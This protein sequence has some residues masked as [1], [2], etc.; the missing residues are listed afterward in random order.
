MSTM[1]A[2]VVGVTPLEAAAVFGAAV[3]APAAGEGLPVRDTPL[4]GDVVCW[5]VQCHGGAGASTIAQ[6]LSHIGDG[7][8]AWPGR[9]DESPCVVLV[10]RES[11]EG[12]NAAHRAIRQYL[13]GAVPE[14]ITVVGL[15]L[16][17][18]S[19]ARKPSPQVRQRSK[20]V[21]SALPA[22]VPVWRVQWHDYLLSSDRVSLPVATAATEPARK[23]S[24][25][26]DV[27]AD[28]LEVGREAALQ[29]DALFNGQ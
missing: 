27:P 9:D 3:V 8:R 16:V 7:G 10:A 26:T 25:D 17:A 15:A 5:L 21:T 14:H 1:S 22:S 12:L 6:M 4:D 28:V 13:A 2:E 23:F 19:P 18:A 29:V 11:L 20:L 24:P